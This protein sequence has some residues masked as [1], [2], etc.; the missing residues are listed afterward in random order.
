MHC[1]PVPPYN[2]E[3]HL[4]ENTLSKAGIPLLKI[5]TDYSMEDIGQLNTRGQ[6]FVE[7]IK[8]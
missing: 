6:A 1:N 4:V 5:E 7:M 3:S 8:K 2:M